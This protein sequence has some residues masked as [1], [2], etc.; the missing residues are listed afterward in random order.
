MSELIH[1]TQGKYEYYLSLEE[2]WCIQLYREDPKS[3]L[4]FAG[5]WGVHEH[6]A[7]NFQ[8]ILEM[9]AVHISDNLSQSNI[10]YRI[11]Q[12]KKEQWSR[13]TIH[14]LKK[15]IDSDLQQLKLTMPFV[16]LATTTTSILRQIHPNEV[17]IILEITGLKDSSWTTY[18]FEGTRTWSDPSNP[19]KM[20]DEMVHRSHLNA[21]N[22][23]EAHD[24]EIPG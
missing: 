5:S 21:C 15:I 7:S 4:V 14:V 17:N 20:L 10:P 1:G 23:I 13:D 9:P 24:L 8:P 12:D 18:L 6:V 11:P 3:E 2:G 19:Y 22:P 16:S